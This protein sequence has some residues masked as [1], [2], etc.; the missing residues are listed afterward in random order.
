[1]WHHFSCSTAAITDTPDCCAQDF[2]HLDESVQQGTYTPLLWLILWV[3]HWVPERAWCADGKK[4]HCASDFQ[5]KKDHLVGASVQQKVP[6][7]AILPMPTVGP[8]SNPMVELKDTLLIREPDLKATQILQHLGEGGPLTS[9]NTSF[10]SYSSRQEAWSAIKSHSCICVKDLN[11]HALNLRRAPNAFDRQSAV[12]RELLMEGSRSSRP[13]PGNPSSNFDDHFH[14]IVDLEGVNEE[15]DVRGRLASARQQ[16]FLSE[17]DRS[18]REQYKQRMPRSGTIN[19]LSAGSVWCLEKLPLT[20][21]PMD[22]VPNK[23]RC[24]VMSWPLSENY[25][26]V[27]S[28]CWMPWFSSQASAVFSARV[29]ETGASKLIN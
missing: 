29:L 15:D 11:V 22:N 16:D 13:N 18:R 3:A 5:I 14:G 27:G 12:P 6:A 2:D 24:N 8:I 21:T 9:W 1:M 23:L 17:V 19:P 20:S 28:D 25:A 7:Q 26:V 10:G 4:H